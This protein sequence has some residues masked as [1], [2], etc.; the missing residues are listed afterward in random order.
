MPFNR[1]RSGFTLVEL[2]IVVAIVGV[3][4]GLIAPSL[5]SAVR[6]AHE[7]SCA[8]NLRNMAL[9]VKTYASQ[10]GGWLP[11]AEPAN[12][13]TAEPSDP[14]YWFMNPAL[15]EAM[16][17]ALVED[18]TGKALGPPRE[19]TVLICPSHDD[20][21]VSRPRRGRVEGEPRPYGLS[22]GMNAVFGLAGRPDHVD[23]RCLSEFKKPS[24]TLLFADA[25]GR[26][27]APGVVFYKGC[28]ADHW[29]YRHNGRANMAFLDAH[30]ES[31]GPDD[32][33][34]GMANRYEP[35]W[36]ARRP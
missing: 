9:A 3:L 31:R 28:V 19:G 34:V 18:E 16:G 11:T 20:P 29:A 23:Q 4:A 25:W 32:V 8:S 33:P 13:Q 36:G 6:T 12:L 24:E 22:Y 5:A 21:C 7:V 26:S 2:L 15:L 10:H 17:V 27:H 30:V 35:F 1:P 14:H